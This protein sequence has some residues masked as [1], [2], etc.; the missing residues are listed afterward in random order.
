MPYKIAG[1]IADIK[2]F[3]ESETLEGLFNDAMGGMMEILSP[4][5]KKGR[6][7][8]V[9]EIKISAPDRTALL[10][11]FLNEVLSLAYVNRE[12]FKKINF[13]KLNETKL[14]GELVGN[15]VDGFGEDIKA[16]T[17]H[18]ANIT[19]NENGNLKITVVFDI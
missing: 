12:S 2:L 17:Y 9:R 19:Q 15:E 6:E 18:E 11:D 8:S 10:I 14:E 7:V 5:I 4:E 16:A 3:V 1:H 13:K